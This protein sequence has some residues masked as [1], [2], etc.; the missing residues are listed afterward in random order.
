MVASLAMEPSDLPREFP[1]E[2]HAL[3]CFHRYESGDVIGTLG[4]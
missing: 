3:A 1:P 4:Y 2:M